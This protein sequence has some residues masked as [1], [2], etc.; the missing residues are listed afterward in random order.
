MNVNNISRDKSITSSYVKNEKP[1]TANNPAEG[2]KKEKET[3]LY[4]PGTNET[5]KELGKTYTRDTATISKLKL[6]VEKQTENLRSIVEKL[7]LQQGEKYKDAG[8]I[9]VDRE[10]AL[11]AQEEISEDGFWG[12]KNTSERLFE[13]AKAVS[14]GDPSKAQSMKDAFIK[15]FEQAKAAW[16]GELPEIS[17]KT[18]DATIKL[19]DDWIAETSSL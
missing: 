1:L 8:H 6:E 13:F 7:I 10:T 3:D 16:G 5:E 11:K 17:Q 4:V 15:G 12:V 14:G 2:V 9:E 18:Y 19:F